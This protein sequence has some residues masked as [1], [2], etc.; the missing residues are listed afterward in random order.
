M[1]DLESVYA[2]AVGSC[3]KEALAMYR[4]ELDR[5][6]LK[7]DGRRE[8]G[9]RRGGKKGM[10]RRRRGGL[11]RLHSTP[12]ALWRQPTHQSKKNPK[13][14]TKSQHPKPSKSTS[15]GDRAR[16]S[17]ANERVAHSAST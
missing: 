13:K 16:L 17:P 15:Y 2:S 14:L 1:C 12:P 6:G 7:V 4:R 8:K 3:G 11:E 10:V 9:W 5:S